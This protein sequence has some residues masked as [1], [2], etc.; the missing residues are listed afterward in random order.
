MMKKFTFT[1]SV[2]FSTIALVSAQS[3]AESGFPNHQVGLYMR[4]D[5]QANQSDNS[6]DINGD[7]DSN[8]FQFNYLRLNF[9]GQLNDKTSY[10]IRYRLDKS[11]D[12]GNGIDSTGPGV[13]YAYIDRTVTDNLKVRVGKQYFAGVCGRE[14]DYSGQDVYKYS[15]TC[16]VN[17]FYRTGVALM[18]SFNGQSF[19]FSA[20]NTGDE[21]SNQDD[22]G[23]AAT[24]YGN[25]A[26]GMF[27][28]IVS[29]VYFPRTEQ[30]AAGG[31]ITAKSSA[32]SYFTVGTRFTKD[33]VQL[34]ADY[35]RADIESRIGEEDQSYDTLALQARLFMMGGKLQPLVKFETSSSDG[36]DVNT[37]DNFKPLDRNAYTV[38]LEYY[39][40]RGKDGVNNFRVH[41]AYWKSTDDFKNSAKKDLDTSQLLLGFSLNFTGA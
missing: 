34:E 37:D 30:K 3:F 10:R 12:A 14:G 39:P 19:V 32:D 9:K 15:L 24:W 41:A 8:R 4:A 28:P 40:D 13:N 7:E 5:A 29:Y 17:P 23:Y 36:G 20:V 38:A 18:P 27:E 31:A 2:L 6:A 1:R 33:I 11:L 22:F 16:D 25:L 26:E 35:M 21:T